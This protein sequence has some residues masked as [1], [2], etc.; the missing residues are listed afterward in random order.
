M[1]YLS[2][3]QNK[4]LI[5][6]TDHNESCAK[7]INDPETKTSMVT[8]FFFSFRDCTNLLHKIVD[9]TNAIGAFETE[10]KANYRYLNQTLSNL[11]TFIKKKKTQ[12]IY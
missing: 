11:L 3:Q 6:C 10:K 12:H 7:F 2:L 8:T 9:F 5:F 1:V 4:L